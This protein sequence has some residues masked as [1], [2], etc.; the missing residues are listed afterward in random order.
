MCVLYR[1]SSGYY[2]RNVL[3]R[4]FSACEPTN[5]IT[6][7][8]RD[9]FVIPASTLKGLLCMWQVWMKHSFPKQ[10][11][12][13]AIFTTSTTVGSKNN[14]TKRSLLPNWRLHWGKETKKTNKDI[15]EYKHRH[16]RWTYGQKHSIF[17]MRVTGVDL[18]HLK[19]PKSPKTC[20]F[21][22]QNERLRIF[23]TYYYTVI[24]RRPTGV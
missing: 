8:H 14:E 15:Y 9:V 10:W 12:P 19:A 23:T 7:A 20:S 5:G 1:T 11:I 3:F 13:T 2:S 4:T 18:A 17:D 24:M 21:R 6:L 16:V 22:R